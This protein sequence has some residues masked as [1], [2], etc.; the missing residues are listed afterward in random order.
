MIGM[1]WRAGHYVVICGYNADTDAFILQDPAA[2]CCNIAVTSATME[3]ARQAWGTDEDL[4]IVPLNSRRVPQANI[5]D[6][7]MYG[8][9]S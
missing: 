6:V 2:G 7:Q 1:P 5:H 4:L 9:C 8:K 3:H